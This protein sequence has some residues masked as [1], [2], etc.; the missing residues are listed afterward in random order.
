MP[1][2]QCV[3]KYLHCE[4]FTFKLYITCACMPGKRNTTIMC[5]LFKEE[6]QTTTI[7]RL[8]VYTKIIVYC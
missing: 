3:F 7:Q 1:L 8:A 6:G 4:M 2:K 5:I